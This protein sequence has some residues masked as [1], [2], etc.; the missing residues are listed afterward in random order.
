MSTFFS[1][2]LAM[3]IIIAVCPFSLY[4]TNFT[5]SLKTDL[6][7]KMTAAKPGDT[8][9][10]KNGTYNW[11]QIAFTNLSGSSKSAWIVLKAQTFNG[12]IFSGNTYLQF[13]G[14]HLLITGFKFTNG[15]AG[16]NDVIQ[17]RGGSG[18]N[19]ALAYYCRINNITIYNYNSDSTGCT[20]TPTAITDTL[21]RWVSFYGRHNRMDHCTF[22]NK[23]NGGPTIAV[24]YD[25]ANYPIGGYS[26]YHL[27]DSNYF[28]GRGW[29]GGNEGETIR[30]GLGSMSNNDGYNVVEHNLFQYGTSTD[31]EIISNKSNLNTYRYNTFKDL[32]G[33]I[34]MRQGRYNSVYGNFIIKTTPNTVTTNQYGIRLIDKGQKVFNNYIE[35]IN[36]NYNS[37]NA[38]IGPIYIYS[39]QAPGEGYTVP[40]PGYYSADSC[41]VAFNSIVNCYGGA[42]IQIGYNH[43]NK[44]LNAPYKPQGLVI[45]NNVI[46]MTKGQ[47]IA[48]D[49]TTDILT[50]DTV[51][52]HRIP[53]SLPVT[54]FAEGNIY[55][56]AKGLGFTNTKG[57]TSKTLTFGTRTNGV[58]AAPTALKDA[59]IN[60][61]NYDSLLSKVDAF[62]VTRSTTY[63]VGAVEANG[64]GVNI[65]IPLDSSMVGAGMPISILPIS[66]ISF[67]SVEVRGVLN[68]KWQ[69][70]NELNIESYHI[71]Y[72]NNGVDFNSIRLVSS[73]NIVSYQQTLQSSNAENNY[74]RLRILS[75]DGTSTY[76]NIV[77]ISKKSDVAQLSL[78]PNPSRGNMTIM[79]NHISSNSQILIH[80][81]LGRTIK[82]QV[83]Q[84][85]MNA[86]NV[87]GLQSG[88]YR[89]TLVENGIVGNG[90]PFMVGK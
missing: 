89:I 30:I 87:S 52:G 86:I 55:N 56:A 66:L 48:V 31:P 2:M 42:G 46:K 17:F 8:V 45:A 72:S 20:A 22:I 90:V 7:N 59:A 49:T 47:A 74:Y 27:I 54:Y 44:G 11:G 40:I 77:L 33:G 32:D 84:N 38:S 71:E 13:G 16:L 51:D 29:Q 82:T 43:S 19:V 4:A 25:S 85:G 57:F 41:I 36:T 9:I 76:S 65:N 50:I 12:V 39:G 70:D 3:L 83:I 80:D 21:N 14:Y 73:Q 35:G 53:D 6:I 24:M 1:K 34:T 63:D 15:N 18:G 68:L 26:T 5:V 69:V 23:Y 10:V 60:S 81:Y 58:L 28:K 78:F 61:L 67:T 64:T 79:A 37:T 75:K 62:G 88:S